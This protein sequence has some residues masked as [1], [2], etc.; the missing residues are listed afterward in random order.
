MS[1]D[2]TSNENSH[3]QK[4]TNYYSTLKDNAYEYVWLFVTP[5]PVSESQANYDN[6][7]CDGCMCVCTIACC[8]TKSICL[9]PFCPF[10]LFCP[11]YCDNGKN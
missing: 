1:T 10:G 2:S 5:Y 4:C 6:K 11:S 8:P 7:E 3:C 9:I